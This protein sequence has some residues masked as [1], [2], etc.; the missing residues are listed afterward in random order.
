[1][2]VAVAS[3]RDDRYY[4]QTGFRIDDDAIADFVT[5]RGGIATF[6]YP[7]SRTFVFQGFVVQ[8]FQ[9]RVVQLDP[10]G[11]PRLLNLLDPGLLPFTSFNFAQFPD[12]DPSVAAAGSST[13]AVAQ[14]EVDSFEGRPVRFRSTFLN[15][16]QS[17]D[18][19]PTGGNADLLP[20]FDLDMWGVPTSQPA[21]DPNNSN[22]VYQRF[23]RGIMQYDAATGLTQGILLGDYLKS[24]LT[25]QSLPLD[26]RAEAGSGSFLLQY[27]P[28]FT[29]G[30]RD[31]VL[32]PLTDLS[33][34]FSPE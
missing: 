5:R 3:I 27:D 33:D 13:N 23:Q 20:G 34:A 25:G 18:A 29:A 16:I 21:L 14:N 31:P 6:G 2:S 19:F 30:V 8:F 4:P 10:T 32:L 24:V 26:L 17:A 22:V 9:R 15:T 1:V 12:Y 28:T 11:H 7:I